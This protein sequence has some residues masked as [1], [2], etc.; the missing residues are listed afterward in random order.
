MRKVIHRVRGCGIGSG[1]WAS[2]AAGRRDLSGAPCAVSWTTDSLTG[3]VL[4]LNNR[5]VMEKDMISLR[6]ESRDCK[7]DGWRR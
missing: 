6:E 4:L 1:N 7:A 2:S 5:I 3:A